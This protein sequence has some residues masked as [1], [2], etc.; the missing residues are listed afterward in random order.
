MQTLCHLGK[1]QGSC[2]FHLSEQES[3]LQK[4][5]RTKGNAL[6]C[7]ANFTI[8]FLY[9]K[10]TSDS[11]MIHIPRN[12]TLQI[13]LPVKTHNEYWKIVTVYW[14]EKATII[15]TNLMS[16]SLVFAK[17]KSLLPYLTYLLW[18]WWLVILVGNMFQTIW[19]TWN[20]FNE[21]TIA[22][23]PPFLKK[24]KIKERKQ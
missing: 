4:E 7:V 21:F 23:I 18:S 6:E 16:C 15:I 11:H 24:K 10:S 1:S 8:L 3:H 17:V 19:Y 14:W 12:C 20:Q 5:K 2:Y 22:V 13:F 9:R